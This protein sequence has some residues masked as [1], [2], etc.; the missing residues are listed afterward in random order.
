MKT[1]HTPELT[2]LSQAE[3]TAISGGGWLLPAIVGGVILQV[4]NHWDHF[5]EGLAGEP[6]SI[7]N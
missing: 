2:E 7:E 4:L 1:Q 6:E 3:S 5:K